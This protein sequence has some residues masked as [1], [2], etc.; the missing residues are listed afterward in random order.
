MSPAAR[1]RIDRRPR[2]LQ[3]ACQ[4][5]RIRPHATVA[6]WFC[7]GDDWVTPIAAGRR[8]AHDCSRG[9]GPSDTPPSPLAQCHGLSCLDA[10]GGR[11]LQPGDAQAEPLEAGGA[12]RAIASMR[13][14]PT[15]SARSD[16]PASTDRVIG[17]RGT[18]SC[19]ASDPDAS[20]RSGTSRPR[21]C[22]LATYVQVAC[23]CAVVARDRRRSYA[24]DV[25]RAPGLVDGW[26]RYERNEQTR[27]VCVGVRWQGRARGARPR[28]C[29]RGR[30]GGFRVGSGRHLRGRRVRARSRR[31]SCCG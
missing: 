1:G 8:R 21:S 23:E 22:A 19:H 28:R 20:F 31:V 14:R 9:A 11:L 15:T 13:H 26:T 12:R 16:R 7:F 18:R 6:S 17:M 25:S 24:I 2:P 29:G 10:A 30:L 3:G 27:W 5:Y 4:R